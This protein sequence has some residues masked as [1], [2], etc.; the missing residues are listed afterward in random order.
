MAQLKSEERQTGN[1][2]QKRKLQV[3]SFIE[4]YSSHQ[5]SVGPSLLYTVAFL[6]LHLFRSIPTGTQPF[7]VAAAA[8]RD[9]EAGTR[10]E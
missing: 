8:D 3:P 4:Y 2:W 9:Q 5:V 1:N 6:T 7:P 10:S